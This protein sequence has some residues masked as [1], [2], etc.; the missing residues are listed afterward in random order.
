[1]AVNTAITP[2]LN[3]LNGVSFNG[4]SSDVLK[5]AAAL[6]ELNKA[7]QAAVLVSHG[8]EKAERSKA[9]AMTENLVA[10]NG[11]TAAEAAKKLGLDEDRVATILNI[12]AT[13]RLTDAQVRALITSGALESSERA[14]IIQ[15]LSQTAATESLTAATNRLNFSLKASFA[16]MMS[17][18]MGWITLIATLLPLVI[19]GVTKLIDLYKELH[20]TLEQLQDDLKSLEEEQED[21][22]TRLD[23]NTKRI[24]ELVDLT[25]RRKISLVEQDELE[26][27]KEENELLDAQRAIQQ[28]LIDAQKELTREKARSEAK[29]FLSTPRKSYIDSGV[30][31][32]YSDF[33]GEAQYKATDGAGGLLNAI[34]LYN[35]ARE[36][37]KTAIADEN[38]REISAAQK[39]IENAINSIKNLSDEAVS[40]M[41]GLDRKRDSAL[42]NNLRKLIDA[43]AI[44]IDKEAFYA[45]K[46]DDLMENTGLSADELAEKF[47]ELS[48]ASD[49]DIARLPP[50]YHRLSAFMEES[51]YAAEEL[52]A[53]FKSL[54]EAEAENLRQE[55]EQIAEAFQLKD[56]IQ[57]VSEVYDVLQAAQKDISDAQTLS[58]DTVAKLSELTDDYTKYLIVENGQLK[59]N[60]DALKALADFRRKEAVAAIEA[61]IAALDKEK[62]ALQDN[63][64]L[65]NEAISQNRDMT[66]NTRNIVQAYNR[67]NEIA[68]EQEDLNA[69]LNIAD[70]VLQSVGVE[71]ENIKDTVKDLASVAKD[72]Y[73][74][75]TGGMKT[76]ANI[77]KEVSDG[78]TISTEK[79]IEFAKSFPEI[80]NGASKS[81]NGQMTLSADSVQ[82]VLKNR[83]AELKSNLNKAISDL[84]SELSRIDGK[85]GADEIKDLNEQLALLKSLRG[86]DFTDLITVEEKSDSQKTVE[87]YVTEIKDFREAL[88]A[89]RKTEESVSGIQQ[90]FSHS[91]DFRER[92]DLQRQLI[93][94]YDDER[95]AIVNL[96]Q[97]RRASIQSGVKSLRNLGFQVRY[98]A[99]SDSLWIANMER[100]NRLTAKNAGE[101]ET[102]QEATNALRKETEDLI[103][104]L[105]DLNAENRE[106]VNDWRELGYAI[107][108]ADDEIQKI[109]SDI[110][111]NASDAVGNIQDVYSTLHKAQDEFHE[112]GY[113]TIET[114]QS[115]V[116]MGAQYVVYLRDENGELTV[117]EERI[118]KVLRAK[119]D[120]LAKEQ[121]LVYLESLQIAAEKND[122]IEL[123]KLLYATENIADK[124][125]YWIQA[126]IENLSLSEKEKRAAKENIVALQEMAEYAARSVYETE[127]ALKKM[128]ESTNEGLDNLR[129][130]YDSLHDAADSYAD[131]GYVAVDVLQKLLEAGAQYESYLYDENGN[132]VINEE[133]IRRVIAA[134]TEQLAVEQSLAYIEAL[135][136]AKAKGDASELQTLLHDTREATD[137]T[138]GLVYAQ[139]KLL[140]LND[141]QYQAALSNIN[142]IRALA[143]NAARGIGKV[144]TSVKEEL[145]TMKSGMDDIIKYVMDM[146][147]SRVQEEIDGLENAKK[148]YADIINRQKESIQLKKKEADYQKSLTQKI[149]EMGKIQSQIMALS[150]DDSR[151]AKAQR[152]KLEESLADLSEELADKQ[153][154]HSIEAAERALDEQQSS[155]EAEKDR[156][157]QIL[158]D[159]VSSTEKLYQA[160]ISYIA[161]NFETLYDELLQWNYDVGSNLETT[162]VE[163]WENAYRAAQ[164]Y[165]D[166]VSA[167]R[168][169]DSDIQT[170]NATGE[171]TVVGKTNTSEKSTKQE[172]I[173]AII[174]EMYANMNAH[175][176]AFSS[177]SAAN[178]K[179]LSKRNLELG[180]M[181]N[182]LGVT[183]YR[184]EN[185]KDWGTWYTDGGVLL[186]DKYKRY[187]YH[188]GG[189]AGQ[190]EVP[191]ILQK[192]ELVIP[193]NLVSTVMDTM[194]T[195]SKLQSAMAF[196]PRN[197]G[198]SL[199]R[200]FD[201]AGNK[202]ENHVINNN[203]SA[204]VQ[205]TFGDTVI[206]GANGDSIG[207]YRRV[208][209]NLADDLFKRLNIR[210]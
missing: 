68:A 115:V 165:G 58:G 121:A 38:Q 134:R 39:Q 125:W 111:K 171:N 90:K 187:I 26:R 141:R 83:S 101:Y 98:D 103:Q 127:S 79:A 80:L 152:T 199:I 78:F 14:R 20:P 81:A 84:Q 29:D 21:L 197:I 151:E 208:T 170:A 188:D 24:V 45:E 69:R 154:E 200:A 48:E 193:K 4:A 6:S 95:R 53:H 85:T 130:V 176:G 139:L 177:T 203:N 158:Q 67:L 40:I 129:S 148:E 61:E 99:Q 159:S 207:E 107:Q 50:V 74:D 155:Y 124:T 47:E 25:E 114:L 182:D 31:G 206:H 97:E 94:A 163:A 13:E 180:A 55:E 106:A 10:L 32:F 123:D 143:E 175:G 33:T 59:L 150:L 116:A 2:V 9:L 64:R 70:M 27:L 198:A 76:L 12:N 136:T 173:H 117:N 183:A 16:L 131:T 66:G 205:I 192:G 51:G 190:D 72:A 140:N 22:Q 184:S 167:M 3:A 174:S 126:K 8:Y 147:K 71:T 164:K 153:A 57:S 179:A 96:N 23:E 54:S 44:A 65:Y 156:E 113:V 82:S 161:E 37:L 60:T 162:I 86:I 52:A 30:N 36:R 135:R 119:S 73:S 104:S 11:L 108:D 112:N 56:A 15:T 46:L 41:N 168:L 62:R 77:Q 18:P 5:Y 1:M 109:L 145:A 34:D 43:A 166:Y 42:Y 133:R 100:L 118:R 189:I 160:A 191:A 122:R 181:L 142:A 204:P 137:A 195:V 7:Q 49:G 19:T 172:Q 169:I 28:G 93:S 194:T 146:L 186:F 132:L 63:I 202:T 120:Y 110:V 196:T 201:F 185:A 87:E 210:R 92:I 88:E 105:E 178:K 89:L 102:L 75:F 157:I 128:I 138:W 209:E 149:R 91:N 35:Q 17:S 144:T